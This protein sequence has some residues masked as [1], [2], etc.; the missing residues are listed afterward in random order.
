MIEP[1]LLIVVLLTGEK[2]SQLLVLWPQGSLQKLGKIPNL[3]IVDP[4]LESFKCETLDE[5]SAKME[6]LE[7]N[8]V[9]S[10]E[11]CGSGYTK[12]GYLKR[13]ME[14]KHGLQ[15]KQVGPVCSECDKVFANPY[16]LVKHMKTHLKCT[17]CKKEFESVEETKLHKKEHAV[18]TICNKD[19]YFVS[20]LSKHVVSMHK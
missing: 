3:D 12:E 5:I 15:K 18:C 2:Q 8:A 4:D 16:N 9:F 7:L 19:F 1:S 6:S 13:H 20:K 14:E 11:Q 17:T 10:C